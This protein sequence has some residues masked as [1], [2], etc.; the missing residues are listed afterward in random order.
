MRRIVVAAL[1]VVIGYGIWPASTGAAPVECV[2]GGPFAPGGHITCDLSFKPDGVYNFTTIT[3]PAGVTVTFARNGANTPVT[4]NAT[5][6]VVINGT[7]NLSAAG[8]TG[9]PGGG[10]GGSAGAA[11][12]DGGDGSGPSPGLGGP[13][14]NPNPGHAGG[15]GGMATAG[16]TAIRH[17]AAPPAAGGTAIAFPDP[18]SG[19]SGGGGGGGWTL[20]GVLLDG[21]VGGGAGG[22]LRIATPASITIAGQILAI[23]A[24]GHYSFANVFGFGGPG[25]GGSGGVIDLAGSAITVSSTA[26]LRVPGGAGGGISTLPIWSP[27]FSSEANGGLGFVRFA[28]GDLVVNGLVEGFMLLGATSA[29]AIDPFLCYKAKRT[30]DTAAPAPPA[31]PIVLADRFQT[32]AFVLK[33]GQALCT[34]ANKEREGLVDPATHL[35]RYQITLARTVPRQPPIARQFGLTVVNQLGTVVV[36]TVKLDRLLVPAAKDHAAF[37]PPPDPDGHHVDHYACYTVKVPRGGPAFTPVRGVRIEDQFAQPKLFDLKKPTRLCA[38][39]DKGA[40]LRENPDLHLM[41]YK[42]TPVRGEPRHTAVRGLHV[43]DQ[44]GQEQLDTVKDEEVCVPS[45]T[46]LP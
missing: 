15:G 2:D 33:K 11:F 38:P 3:I 19:G 23:G 45:L 8:P 9:G 37:L 12:T 20:F 22:G 1:V 24:D 6:D 44:F 30:A 17:S 21:G 4:W 42:A 31:G 36:D 32:S 26:Q 5:G 29:H 10:D 35:R 43:T 40:E 34:P 28:T 41:C 39:A 18:L 14:G 27:I 16:S 25:G 7:V 46:L 13:R